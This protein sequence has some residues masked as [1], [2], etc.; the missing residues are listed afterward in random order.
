MA[1]ETDFEKRRGVSQIE[2]R[3]GYAQVHVSRLEGNL[4]E[5]RLKV[6][7]SLADAQVT[8]D[9]L[10]LTPSGLSCLVKESQEE[11][12]NQTLS[13]C[14]DHFTVRGRRSIVIVH[15]V[16]MRD[17]EGLLAS[18]I[19]QS[20]ACKARIDHICDMHDRMLIIVNGEDA[21][22]LTDWLTERLL[23]TEGGRI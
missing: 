3:T 21:L 15:A 7:K 22:K 8:I 6:L 17:E 13:P 14:G 1:H 12:V 19:E 23:N 10:K 5:A 4:M 9:F 2:V 11:L 20:I 18:V 16:N